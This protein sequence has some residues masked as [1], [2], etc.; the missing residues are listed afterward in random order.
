MYDQA[1]NGT[2]TSEDMKSL[3]SG[4]GS[5]INEANPRSP[6]TTNTRSHPPP[7]NSQSSFGTIGRRNEYS[8]PNNNNNLANNNNN[9][10]F[11]P[12]IETNQ[13]KTSHSE[14]TL[15]ITTSITLRNTAKT[16]K[17]FQNSKQKN[18]VR[19]G[20]SKKKQ[21]IGKKEKLTK[22]DIGLPTNFVHIE[23]AGFSASSGFTND[24][25]NEKYKQIFDKAGISAMQLQDTETK[26]FI[27]E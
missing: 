12:R 18:A 14:T 19:K 21:K 16:N 22:A 1:N 23:H 27:Y 26:A 2:L 5:P 8:R 11:L 17:K 13:V 24:I 6:T 15:P 7:A 4:M 20:S 9:A 25:L 3:L 10:Q